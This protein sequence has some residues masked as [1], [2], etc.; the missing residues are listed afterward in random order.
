MFGKVNDPLF[1]L[2]IDWEDE[3]I[4]YSTHEFTFLNQ[5]NDPVQVYSYVESFSN[6][7]SVLRSDGFGTSDFVIVNLLDYYG[8][9]K[10]QIDE[11]NLFKKDMKCN[12]YLVNKVTLSETL[13]TNP[14]LTNLEQEDISLHVLSGKVRGR[15][16]YN[17]Q[18]KIL[19]VEVENY[20]ENQE[21]L[22][23]PDKEEIIEPLLRNFLIE[24]PWPFIQGSVKNL[25]IPRLAKAPSM[26]VA[27]RLDIDQLIIIINWHY[28]GTAFPAPEEDDPTENTFTLK[29]NPIDDFQ[30]PLNEPLKF[31]LV[32]REE[33]FY[34]VIIEGEFISETEFQFH[35]D[36]VTAI[37]Y[38]NVQIEELEPFGEGRFRILDTPTPWLQ[39]MFVRIGHDYT[40]EGDFRNS[41]VTRCRRQEGDICE[42]AIRNFFS[43]TVENWEGWEGTLYNTIQAAAKMHP[44]RRIKFIP[45]GAE[46]SLMEWPHG[47]YYVVSGSTDVIVD[48]VKVDTSDGMVEIPEAAYQ[49]IQTDGED[50]NRLFDREGFEGEISH[51]PCTYIHFN[52]DVFLRFYEQRASEKFD[53]I[54]EQVL[55]DCHVDPD[56]LDTE[57]S[58]MENMFERLQKQN[59]EFVLNG[60]ISL[61]TDPYTV[62]R[63]NDDVEDINFA[64]IE[65][66]DFSD[67]LEDYAWQTGAAVR[68]F[69]KQ[70][71]LINRINSPLFLESLESSFTFN[72]SNVI[73][74]SILLSYTNPGD[75]RT[76]FEIDIMHP[77]FSL[78]L[79]TKTKK[80]NTKLY[81]RIPER[82]EFY[83]IDPSQEIIDFWMEQRSNIWL[84]I[85][86][87]T[88]LEAT[89]LRN[90]D[91]VNVELS[92]LN[93]YDVAKGTPL[94]HHIHTIVTSPLW[95]GQGYIFDISMNRNLVNVTV[96]LPFKVGEL[97]ES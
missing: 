91:L 36:D 55:V 83:T 29:L 32:Y 23:I 52:E 12:L 82:F 65:Q 62:S 86:F 39:H 10:N 17:Q 56:S 94:E 68:V 76:V 9:F 74:N 73:E 78:D 45:E 97:I 16:N 18:N 37:W 3:T 43:G 61:V 53:G 67:I 70:I 24:E 38:E 85:S 89:H 7:E 81:G 87:D 69:G 49:V 88:T 8:H 2:S 84:L 63:E 48:R 30:F 20:N 90:F 47:E 25:P 95:S 66:E 51:P 26:T 54:G 50:T 71:N 5:E 59:P 40:G 58:L 93:F 79:E 41:T 75:V 6:V 57:L 22:Y 96:K 77:D 27:E 28:Q 34:N 80:K 19:S 31:N 60:S 64:L 92:N 1:I 42:I 72:D 14:N 21:L 33:T 44:V 46:M 15:I 4:Y 35:R 13:Q 11:Y